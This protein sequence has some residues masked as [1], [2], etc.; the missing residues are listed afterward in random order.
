MTLWLDVAASQAVLL[1]KEVVH[2]NGSVHGRQAL[3]QLF[4]LAVLERLVVILGVER[5]SP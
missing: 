2:G 1:G 3:R 5:V 4:W